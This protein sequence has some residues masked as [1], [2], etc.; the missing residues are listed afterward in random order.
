[1]SEFQ[2]GSFQDTQKTA[3]EEI[4]N[5]TLDTVDRKYSTGYPQYRGCSGEGLL[6][7][8]GRHARSVGHGALRV[9][10]AIDVSPEAAKIG[11]VAGY[12]H[13][14]YQGKG[15]EMR[16]RR[17]LEDQ[18]RKKGLPQPLAQ[19]AGLA[20]TGTEPIFSGGVISGQ[21]ATKQRYASREAKQVALAVAS[22]DL[23][24]LYMP[25][26]PL[27]A[28][29]LY[30]EIHA[31]QDPAIDDRL[32]E[33]QQTQVK[34]L[35]SYSYPLAQATKVLATHKSQVMKYSHKLLRQLERGD[36]DTW[37]QLRAQDEAFY[38]Q[39]A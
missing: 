22:A 37:Q 24:S 26:G 27:L 6:Y 21:M 19:M 14:I 30:R 33:F 38:R 31:E 29:D 28:H 4:E 9:A 7:H 36:I 34:M 32:L 3:L 5:D 16:S 12:A 25:E 15:H 35:E 8:N 13:D 23:G 18:F 2:F 11:E 17:W 1:M 20:I 10:M 39:Y